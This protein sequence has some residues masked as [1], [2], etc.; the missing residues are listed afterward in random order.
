MMDN[1][2]FD[3]G[4]IIIVATFFA[5][6]AR[7]LKQP[8]IPAYVITGLI[9]GPL[10][11]IIT[12]KET[13]FLL[14][15]IGIAFLLFIVG[16]EINIKKLKDVGLVAPIGGTIQIIILFSFGFMVATFLKYQNIEAIYMGAI[17]AFSSTMIVLKLLSDK[18][19]LDTLHGRIILG[20]LL[21]E[22]FFAIL[23]ISILPTIASL[24]ITTL[25]YALLKAVGIMILSFGLSKFIFPK[26][27]KFAAK[28]QEL[29]FLLSI[30][31][32][33]L[34][35]MAFSYIGFSI[36]I[37]AFIA[38]VTLANL[39]YNVEIIGKVTSLKDFFATIFFVS[40]GMQLII[41]FSN[42]ILI[43]LVIFFLFI[44][45]IKPLVTMSLTSFFGFRKRTAFMTGI[46]LAQISE[47]SL[48]IASQGLF[49]GH[50]T[51]SIFTL[52]VLLAI[53]TIT[54][55]SYTIKYDEWI[56]K[57]FKKRLKIFDKFGES[58]GLEYTPKKK[59]DVILCGHN[60]IGYSIARTLKKMKKGL[61]VV[62]FNP[63]IIKMM[64]AKKIPCIYGDLGDIEV[65]ERLPVK[66]ANLLIST[67]PNAQDN[68]LLLKLVKQK[69]KSLSVYVTAN[70]IEDA[71]LLYNAGADYVILPHFLGGEHVS[72]L[73]E[74]FSLNVG[75]IIETK[76]KH[77]QE[78]KRR[79]HMGHEHPRHH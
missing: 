60:R 76:L 42:S 32:C 53:G 11:N 62:D 57:F 40:L 12:N 26:I 65:I 8:L 9:I 30:S 68:L 21:T 33:F 5:Y 38:G 19:E 73:I 28:S 29:L 45:L 2:F 69:N 43:P 10:M 54:I 55:T 46:S 58:S 79:Q 23:A 27:F 7:L 14:A 20:F 64:I 49:L 24:N 31:I 48:I 13:V 4:L 72:L 50:I 77:I 59:I 34:F 36:I 52:T 47:F 22:D 41:N 70:Q 67:V 75:K 51:N 78:L 71:L 3:L 17:L 16:L 56:Y 61:F 6:L 37:G 35:A 39:P 18:K 1:I 15:E 25:V 74:D 63:E 66:K 44:I